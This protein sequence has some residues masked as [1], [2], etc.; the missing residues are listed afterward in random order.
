MRRRARVASGARFAIGAL[1]TGIY[2]LPLLWMVSTSIKPPAELMQSPPVLVTSAPQIE[3]YKSVLGLPNDRPELYVSTLSYLKNSIVIGASTMAL[4]LLLAVPAAYALARFRLRAARLIILAVLVAQMLPSALL[5]MPL[6]VAVR[7]VG[8][9]GSQLAVIIADTALALPFGIILL[10]TSFRQ[11]PRDIEEAAWVDGAS[12]STTLRRVVVPL[13]RPGIVAVAVFSFLTAWGEFVFALSFLPDVATQPISL[14]VFQFVGMY[15]TQW[16]SMMA[17]AA[18]VA[19]PAVI[20][21]LLLKGQ[22]VS[23]LTAGSVKS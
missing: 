3:S 16:D 17:F 9:Y 8:L 1:V 15:K 14:G 10:H 7:S 5:V 11:V 12:R 21:L 19:I 23:G 4:T 20:A 18:I 6:F 13:V 22:F 2:L